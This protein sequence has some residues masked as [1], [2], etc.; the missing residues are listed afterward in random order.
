LTRLGFKA[1]VAK[2]VAF[3]QRNN[4]YTMGELLLARLSP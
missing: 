1:A 3:A 4:R 2:E